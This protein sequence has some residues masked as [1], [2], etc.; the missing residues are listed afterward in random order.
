MFIK[1]FIIIVML[2]IIGALVSSLIFLVRDEGKT[3]RTVKALTLRIGLSIALFLFLFVAFYFH[4][5][6]PHGV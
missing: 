1:I 4:W 3:Q 5:I 2:V 6:T